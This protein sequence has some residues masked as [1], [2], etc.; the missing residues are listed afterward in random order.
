ML[1]LQFRHYQHLDQELHEKE[2]RL[3]HIKNLTFSQFSYLNVLR[4]LK[5]PMDTNQLIALLTTV[6]QQKIFVINS[7]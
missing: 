6:A 2:S 3:T 1:R 4:A 7:Y 5:H